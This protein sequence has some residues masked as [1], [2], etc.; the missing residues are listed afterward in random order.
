MDTNVERDTM[1]DEGEYTKQ[2]F[3]LLGKHDERGERIVVGGFWERGGKDINIKNI[4]CT[5]V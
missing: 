1:I 3:L 2:R 4:C 5:R